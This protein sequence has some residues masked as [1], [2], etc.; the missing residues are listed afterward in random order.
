ME[1][2]DYNSNFINSILISSYALLYK[3]MI[4]GIISLAGYKM[5]TSFRKNRNSGDFEFIVSTV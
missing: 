1:M 4:D 2:I 5:Y 3:G